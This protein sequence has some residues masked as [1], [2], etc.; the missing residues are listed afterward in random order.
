M[1][2]CLLK[3]ANMQFLDVKSVSKAGALSEK[4]EVKREKTLSEKLLPPLKQTLYLR[5]YISNSNI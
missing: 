2:R 3:W 5:I 1:C 4:R